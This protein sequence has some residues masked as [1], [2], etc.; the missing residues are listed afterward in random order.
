MTRD[1][2]TADA[3]RAESRDAER[4]ERRMPGRHE[5]HHIRGVCYCGDV[6]TAEEAAP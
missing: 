5:H 6:V 1:D 3:D 4:A 2:T